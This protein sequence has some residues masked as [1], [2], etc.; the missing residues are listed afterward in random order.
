[1][2]RTDNGFGI[3]GIIVVTVALSTVVFIAWRLYGQVANPSA[4]TGTRAGTATD[5]YSCW[6]RTGSIVDTKP[7]TCTLEGKR[8]TAPTSFS[9]DHIAFLDR[10]PEA[11]RSQL[12]STAEQVFEDCQTG[13]TPA[14]RPVVTIAQDNFV[15]IRLGCESYGLR[16]FALEDNRWQATGN[17]RL[18]ISC[19]TVE[20]YGITQASYIGGVTEDTDVCFFSDGRSMKIP[21]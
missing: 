17:A 4:G 7:A 2:R 19:E 16:T 14:G 3:L 9:Q 20:K 11:V 6:D 15:A 21:S 1:M 8:Y 10:A 12:A 5:F 18:A 13:K